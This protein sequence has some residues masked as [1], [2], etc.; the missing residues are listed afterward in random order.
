MNQ[1]E[2]EKLGYSTEDSSKVLTRNRKSLK[3]LHQNNSED[4]NITTD[5]QDSNSRN[6]VNNT[7]SVQEASSNA[8]VAVC[9]VSCVEASKNVLYGLF[10]G[11]ELKFV[12]KEKSLVEG[13]KL[14]YRQ[15]GF[16]SCR[17]V[18]LIV[19]QE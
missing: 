9:D 5:V 10:V 19:D 18:K 7:L 3:D 16:Y 4:R 13:A 8:C 14:A 2:K 17:S 12:N 6:T 15:L 11:D 1:A